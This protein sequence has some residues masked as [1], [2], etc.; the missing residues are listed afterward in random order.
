MSKGDGPAQGI[1]VIGLAGR[2]PGADSCARFWENLAA[3][4]EA[5]TFWS[6]EE[7]RAAGVAPRLLD[8][9]AYVRA[10]GVVE[11]AERFDAALFGF[12]PREA[13]IMDPQHRVLLE[14]AWQALE[15][16]GYDP[17]RYPGLIGVYAGA[18]SNTYLLF[19]LF[20]N[21][22]L[23]ERVGL[24]QAMLGNEAG[25][26]ATRIS[27]ELNLKGP[28]L[29]VETACSTS[30]V[31]VHLAAQSLLNGECDMALAGGVRIA[32]PRRSGYLYEPGGILSPDGHCRPFDA[33]AAGCVDG[34]GA[35]VVVLKR[36][37]DARADGDHVHA[38]ILGSAINNDGTGKVGYTA[39][40]VRGQAEVIAMAQAIADVAPETIGYLEAHGTATPMGDPIEV[41]ALAEVFG[42]G[43]KSCAL[44][45]VKSNIGHLDAAAGVAGL[46]K[47]ILALEHRQIPPTVHFVRPN[48]RLELDPTPFYVNAALADWPAGE[49]PRRAGV[50]SFGIG[51][52]NA[53]VVL[54]E[55]PEPAASGPSRASQ[56]LLLS[57]ATAPALEAATANLVAHLR[58]HP[59]ESLADLA[60][61]L[62]VG[63][64]ALPHRRLVVCGSIAETVAALDTLDPQ[65]VLSRFEESPIRG[66]AFLFPGQGSQRPGMAAELY[67]GEPAFRREVD[68]S[69]AIL[70]PA[71]GLD[72]RAVLHPSAPGPE[73]DARLAETALA[74]PALFVVEHALARLLMEWGIRPEAMLGHS[75][76]E[77]V[78]ACLAGVFTLEEALGLVDERGRL[79]QAAR[80]G[81]MLSVALAE[82]A[83]RPQ[84]SADL[85]VA[86]INSP[87]LC[88][89]AGPEGAVAALAARL[90]EQGVQHRRLATSH[91]FH[92][93]S[94]EPV[95][96]RFRAAVARLDLKPPAIPFLSNRT[97]TWIRAEEATD[98]EYWVSHLRS[99]VRFSEGLEKL[100]ADPGLALLEVGPGRALAALARQHPGRSS[101]QLVLSSLPASREAGSE[102]AGLLR[103][104]G[105]LWLAGT[106]VDWRGFYAGERRQRLALPTYPF[107]RQRF[108]VE[109]RE[110][111]AATGD[112]TAPGRLPELADRFYVPLW[113]QALPPAQGALREAGTWLLFLDEAG[114]GERLAARLEERGAQVVTVRPGARFEE[115]RERSFALRPEAPEDY[116]ALLA[117][118]G[119]ARLTPARIAHLWSVTAGPR[120]SRQQDQARTEPTACT[121]EGCLSPKGEF[122]HRPQPILLSGQLTE[123]E[124][125]LGFYS[126]LFLAQALAGRQGPAPV[127]LG[128]LST[129]L[130]AVTGEEDLQ[131]VKAA[132]LGPVLTLPQELPGATC[133]SLDLDLPEPGSSRES[134]LLDLLLAELTAGLKGAGPDRSA[135]APADPIVAFRGG[136]RW[137]RTFEPLRLASPESPQSLPLR[138][139]GVYLLTGGLGGVGLELAAFLARAVR[140]RLVLTGRSPFPPRE[141]WRAR[142]SSN[143][144]GDRA[145]PVIRRLLALEEMGAEVLVAAADVADRQ[146]MA[147]VLA[148]A[149][150]RFSGLHGVIHAAG[151]AGG[152]LIQLKTRQAAAQVLSPKVDGTLVLAE[153]LAGEELDFFVLCSSLQAILGGPGQVDYVAANAFLEAFAASQARAGRGRILSIAWDTWRGLGMAAGAPRSGAGA[154]A[155]RPEP[156]SAPFA[157]PLLTARAL[158]RNTGEAGE[159]GGATAREE[160]FLSYLRPAE[161]WILAE[162]RLGGHAIVPGTAYLEMAGAAFRGLAG[163]GAAAVEL[164]DVL[165]VTPMRIADDERR[166]VRTVLRANGDGFHFHV[167][168]AD[169]T[170]EEWQE[171]AVGK[172][173]QI[174]AEPAR[175]DLA[176]LLAGSTEE[177]VGETYLENL[178]LVGLGPRWESLK[179]VYLR[180]EAV[181]GWLELAPEFSAD[182]EQFALHPALLDVATSFGE[183]YAPRE[184]GYYLPLSYRRLRAFG[185]LPRRLWSYARFKNGSRPATE[186]L[187]FDIAILDEEGILRV[188]VEEFTLKRVNVASA[189]R[190]RERGMGE[191]PAAGA[192][193]L[194]SVSGAAEEGLDAADGVEAFRRILAGGRLPQVAVSAYPLPEVI[195]RA[196]SL[197]VER[198][199]QAAHPGS[200]AGH[201][202]PDLATPYVAPRNEREL[203]LAAIW[204]EILGLAQVGVFD[205]FFE[206]GGHSLL[207]TQL[208]SRL[209]AELQVEV[210]L[211]RL[212]EAPTVAGLAAVIEAER[213]A[214][215]LPETGERR[216]EGGE[217]PLAAL[218]ETGP[219]PL[220]FAQQR[221]WFLDRLDPGSAAYNM[222]RGLS[223]SG[224]F[225]AR[226]RAALAASMSEIVRRHEVLR[227]T[228]HEIAGEP[229]QVVSP[230]APLA[231]VPVPF[232]DLAG[233]AVE[234][235]KREAVRL[236]QEAARSPFD[237]SRGP[238]IRALLLRLAPDDHQV[239]V[240]LHHIVTDG[241]SMRVFLAE[242]W[243]LYPAF[244]AGRPSPLPELPIQYR[245]FALWQRRWLAEGALAEQLA[246]WRG[247]LANPPGELD[248]PLDR[249]RPAVESFRGG[250]QT[251]ALPEPLGR[252]LTALTRRH[253]A[254]LAMTLLAGLTALLARTSGQEDIA[255]GVAIA[256]R[257]RRE[258]EDLIGF[259]VNTLVFRGDL[260]G[261]A[262]FGELLDRVRQ[263]ALA[264]YAH[265]DLPFEK[266]VEEINPVRTLARPPLFQVLFG[267]E[268]LPRQGIALPGLTVSPLAEEVIDTGTSKFDLTLFAFEESGA[269]AG[270]LEYNAELLAASTIHRLLGHFTA[271]LAQAAAHPERPWRDLP[272][273]SP[274]ERAQLAEWNDTAAPVRQAPPVQ[275]FFE[276]QAE[277]APAAVAVEM[278]GEALSYG[279]LESRANRLAWQL[280]ELGVGPESAVGICLP[281][282]L[283]MM[284]AVLGAL[285]AGGAYVPLDP[286][287]PPERLGW[288]V[289]DARLAALV[290]VA[291]LA[292]RL[293]S[294]SAEQSRPVVLLDVSVL[295]RGTAGAGPGTARPAVALSGDELAYILYTSGSTGRPKGIAMPHRPLANLMGWQLAAIPAP[296]RTLQFSSLGFDVSCQ[297]MFATWGAGGTLV[298]VDEETRRDAPALVRLLASRRVERLLLPFVALQQLAEAARF[299]GL[300]DALREVITAGEQLRASGPIV[301]LFRRLP[302]CRL[303]NQYGPTETHIATAFRLAEDPLRW[304]ALPPIGRPLANL[305][306][307]VRAA[308]PAAAPASLAPIGVPGELMIGGAGLARGYLGRPDLTAERFLPDPFGAPGTRLYR[309]GDLA[310]LLPDGAI[311][312]LGRRDHQVKV[313]GFRVEPGEIEAVLG[314]HPGVREAVVVS[315][316][317]SGGDARLVAYAVPRGESAPPLA[318][319]TAHLK[320][321]LPDYMVPASIVL[322]PALPVNPNGKVDRKA[323]PAPPALHPGSEAIASPRTPVEELVGEIWAD[324]LGLPRVGIHDNFFALGGHSLLATRMIARLRQAFGVE[325]PLRALFTRPTVA[326]L[327]AALAEARGAGRGGE[328]PL[329]RVALPGTPQPLS[330]SQLRFWLRRGEGRGASNIPLG[331]RFS[332]PLDA[333]VLAASLAE[334]VRRHEVLRAAFVEI[335][336][337]PAQVVRDGFQLP[338]AAV[339]LAALP[340]ERRQEE[341]RRLGLAEAEYPFD[342]AREPLVR[343]TLVRLAAGEHALLLVQHH[344]VTDGWSGGILAEELAE[345][346]RACRA[347]EPSPLPDLPLQYAD[348]AAWQRAYLAGPVFDELLS[349]WQERLRDLPVLALPTDRPRP[350]VRSVRGALA[351]RRLDE[352]LSRGAR[353]LGRR[354]NA[355]LFMT[356]LAA[357]QALLGLWTGQE[358]VALTTNVAN[359]GRAESE[360]LIGLFTNVVALRTS[361]SGDPTFG[362]LLGRVREGA[363][364]AFAHQDLPFIEIL[365]R[366]R[367]GRAEIYNELFPAGF[368]LQNF[369]W[370]PLAFPDLAVE[371]LDLASRSAPRDLILL[372]EEDGAE[373]RLVLLYREDIFT[374]RTI[375]T[376]LARF[377]GLLSAVIEDPDRRLSGLA[378]VAGGTP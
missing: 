214:A 367:P 143:A 371:P 183:M 67:R 39:P 140:A 276:R 86:A 189:I 12:S 85:E 364:E 137:R 271:L 372:A 310:R 325:V 64:R 368:V 44:G 314:A 376:L 30:L 68:R 335:D 181:L 358:D 288:M 169:G 123:S 59:E 323:L 289:E 281:R 91:A 268:N 70:R 349:Y 292:G 72:L 229:V 1:A 200:A 346:Y 100:L 15:H 277:R 160:V 286:A 117:R 101:G 75:I 47:A 331:L 185:R 353:E 254:T 252:G 142:A 14:C 291:E 334:I 327:A 191:E 234:A 342:L 36:L 295:D 301:D 359:R 239:S 296:R 283:A 193:L 332:G 7:L 34:E 263:T 309:S 337:E 96:D 246:Y 360:R 363:L 138:E 128:V 251:F 285:K 125:A 158:T 171:H 269:V 374:A 347:G 354:A 304:A 203:R 51:G 57:A 257:N 317:H 120:L 266:L 273:L 348:F 299:A 9:P 235:R 192:A 225:D 50:S 48:P 84:L 58:Q 241:W 105:Q 197:T 157:H 365:N 270:V 118:L 249:P 272:L 250:I 182:L 220:S 111:A 232:V 264:A 204:G 179:K 62:K 106:E 26:L 43:E 297:E 163:D 373:I 352:A 5:I 341:L 326:G 293:P 42:S 77:L 210:P 71:L 351:E 218:R 46:L 135:E 361:L 312:F 94:M 350:A 10:R 74:Q 161:S 69:L 302:G 148:L 256:G 65:Q 146:A 262:G 156:R 165:F 147:G 223:L 217:P 40:S 107:E 211:A 202:R 213:A 206:L 230:P 162:H 318:E 61:T 45:S 208:V 172:I 112:R 93:A 88:V 95:L 311:E 126:L 54:E 98:P 24:Y 307:W 109:P 255:V 238:L 20:G 83:V 321:S 240:V 82:S 63:R 216:P 110:S 377:A 35:G 116:A 370:R 278:D 92:S 187:T 3:G 164:S 207:G 79:M 16:A 173:R 343:A 280:L 104:V 369:P 119:E 19:N 132:L 366:L 324:L 322:L 328:P 21:R 23:V 60:Y 73:D 190:R 176:L 267:F 290:T 103:A 168:S 129:G 121:P 298:L 151:I 375:E 274:A 177:A 261:E 154:P 260:S 22:D 25:F 166:E 201:A 145:L 344:M 287:Y 355:S 2:F 199:A 195:E 32:A 316:V 55:A 81:A 52:T 247:Q 231:S 329:V 180:D 242:T 196:R 219:A 13:E 134:E 357:W 315:Q 124:L 17:E 56:L 188:Q 259:F 224:A 275:V 338:L 303:E 99:T 362:E 178:R 258:I 11:G 130:H 4:R 76:G 66:V 159:Q 144:P 340:A 6:A 53:H 18:G 87:S 294:R 153:L 345:L 108:W 378:G 133:Q 37:A 38:V 253:G 113:R 89:V 212:F 236:A 221:L 233:L 141:E 205:D 170:G 336:G 28:S 356:L 227:T 167:R 184:E 29:T 198:L 131:P 313:R 194:A 282:S 320:A 339:D 150:E 330:Y 243:A 33:A 41:A 174:A 80:P 136:R 305:R 244:R 228:F 127:H 308:D 149:R 139:R 226:D 215:A 279:E 155:G 284:V 300:P 8:D 175:F 306:N 115:A 97:G 319:L 49:T 122:E 102:T 152:G 245:D 78:A 237:L 114:L 27:Y 90:T 186:T 333:A 265:Q 31:A 222:A 248:L 209:R